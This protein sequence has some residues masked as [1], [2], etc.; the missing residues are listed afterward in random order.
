MRGVQV[1]E[2]CVVPCR[3]TSSGTEF[4]LVTPL[5][6]NRWEF[7][8]IQLDGEGAREIDHLKKAAEAVG[9]R[10]LVEDDEPLGSYM[11]SR[12]NETRSM[13]GFL[14]RV[15]AVD[16]AWARQTTH[17]RLWC[18]AEEARVRIRRKPLRRFID[19]ALA[20]LS[21]EAG[22]GSARNGKARR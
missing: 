15:N 11:S 6:E 12:N 5:A 13:T 14:M 22:N 1:H 20:R 16:D 21:R 3:V 7:P 18:L 2:C 17:R 4:C 8:K 10:G 19:L 9:V